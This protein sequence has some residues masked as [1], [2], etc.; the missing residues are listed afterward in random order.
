MMT[1]KISTFA[2]SRLLAALGRGSLL[3]DWHQLRGLE[4]D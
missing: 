1:A 2:N 4:Q 3:G